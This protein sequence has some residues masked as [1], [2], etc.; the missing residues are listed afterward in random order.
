VSRLLHASSADN[1]L[2]GLPGH[3]GTGRIGPSP[4]SRPKGHGGSANSSPGGTGGYGSKSANRSPTGDDREGLKPRRRLSII[5]D[6]AARAAAAAAAH[7]EA[8]AAAIAGG[9]SALADRAQELAGFGSLQLA[10]MRRKELHFVAP[11][12]GF[13]DGTEHISLGG[14]ASSSAVAA[15]AAV[16][17]G[18]GTPGRPRAGRRRSS[19]TGAALGAAVAVA[20]LQ[21][22]MGF[23][24][25][26]GGAGAVAAFDARH[27]PMDAATFVALLEREAQ[28]K[29]RLNP[30]GA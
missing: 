25:A 29:S 3:D 1:A 30:L 6:P 27:K 10:P 9:G 4:G 13:S 12:E 19:L 23:D 7:A 11:S 2:F 28:N 17:G 16:A 22:H 8:A 14:G 24:S 20:A 26:G 21:K 5:Q 15:A 18:P